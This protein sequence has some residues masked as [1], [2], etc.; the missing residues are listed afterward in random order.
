MQQACTTQRYI[1]VAKVKLQGLN[2]LKKRMKES[3]E[4]VIKATAAALN[5]EA[6][7]IMTK[8]KELTPVALGTLR[9]S[10]HVKTPQMT[11]TK[12]SITL[13][14]GGPAAPYAIYVHEDLIKY[15]PVG[16]AKFL[17]APFRDRMIVLSQRIALAVGRQLEKG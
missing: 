4:K 14:F 7:I 9:A 17:E 12:I 5:T 15:H 10:G 8:A 2:K 11:G 6:E 13:G 16:Q 1:S 3:P